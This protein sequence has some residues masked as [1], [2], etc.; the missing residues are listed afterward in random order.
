MKD[1]G[2]SEPICECCGE[3][4]AWKECNDCWGEGYVDEDEYEY[5]DSTI[6]RPNG[7]KYIC[8]TCGGA[9]GYYVCP[10]DNAR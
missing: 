7:E 9:G 5:D 8:L 10:H 6:H 3:Y 1:I 4:A 2:I